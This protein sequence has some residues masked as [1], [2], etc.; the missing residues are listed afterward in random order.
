MTIYIDVLFASNL[1][2]DYVTLLAAARFGGSHV[3]RLRLIGAA[4]FGGVYAVVAAMVPVAG[5]L[6]VQ[7][8]ALF[9]MC[10]IAFFGTAGFGRMCGLYLLVSA[11]FA[12]LAMLLGIMTGSS[13]RTLSGYYFAVPFKVLLVLAVIGYAVSG[14]LLRGDAAHG[15]I[16]R[17][18]ERFEITFGQRRHKVSLLHDNG[19][20]LVEPISGKPVFILGKQAVMPIVVECKQVIR[21]LNAQNASESLTRLPPDMTKKFGLLPYQAVGIERGMLLYFRPDQVCRADGSKIDCVI[22]ISPEN[23]A[24]SGYEGLCG[25]LA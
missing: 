20:H 9:V 12:G 17:E 1:L 13:M 6:I 23:I 10:M 18:I 24:E 14:F 3:S 4:V 19:N 25:A 8:V 21:E 2:M 5:G 7:L 15:V 22:A 16:R 11:A